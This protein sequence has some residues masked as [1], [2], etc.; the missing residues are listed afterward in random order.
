MSYNFTEEQKK[1]AYNNLPEHIREF[2]SSEEVSTSNLNIGTKYHLHID[3]IGKMGELTGLAIMGLVPFDD[4]NKELASRIGISSD[5]VNLIVYDLNQQIFSKI[6]KEL[7]ELSQVKSAPV[8]PKVEASSIA[9]PTNTTVGA[10]TP[11]IFNEKMQ[12]VAN[13][14]KQEVAVTPQTGDNKTRDPYREPIV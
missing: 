11:Q 5:T 4:F 7:E 13:V 6:R 9:K 8:T 2:Y 12:G 3:A 1:Q 10:S 14:P